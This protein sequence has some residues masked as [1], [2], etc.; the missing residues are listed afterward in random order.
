[1]EVVNDSPADAI[2]VAAVAAKKWR[3]V[4]LFVIGPSL[5]EAVTG[6]RHVAEK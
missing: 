6:L 1:M 4:I 5:Q 2:A 3:L